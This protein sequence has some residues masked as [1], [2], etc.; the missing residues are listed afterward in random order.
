MYGATQFIAIIFESTFDVPN[1][2]GMTGDWK[3]HFSPELNKKIDEWID[4]N[5]A[6]TE[7]KFITELENQQWWLWQNISNL[8]HGFILISPTTDS[9]LYTELIHGQINGLL[10]KLFIKIEKFGTFG[11]YY[12]FFRNNNRGCNRLFWIFVILLFLIRIKI[13]LW[14]ND[15]FD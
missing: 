12:I 8:I 6:G 11:S 10:H 2:S 7:L 13:L 5:L 14:N 1:C 3:N 15:I 4:K 9:I